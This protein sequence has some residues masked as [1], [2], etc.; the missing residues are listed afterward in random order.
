MRLL[1]VSP[2]HSDSQ[3][4]KVLSTALLALLAAVALAV[5][6]RT[7]DDVVYQPVRELPGNW[8]DGH[9]RSEPFRIAWRSSGYVVD[10]ELP[11]T[12]VP[13]EEHPVDSSTRHFTQRCGQPAT[14]GVT[15]S[16]LRFKRVVAQYTSHTVRWCED[17]SLGHALR[18]EIGSFRAR[19]GTGY[20]IQIDAPRWATADSSSRVPLRL[21]MGSQSGAGSRVGLPAVV[22]LY[23]LVYLGII[24]LAL[25]TLL[26]FMERL[27]ILERLEAHLQRRRDN[28]PAA[29][30]LKPLTDRCR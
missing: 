11:D 20:S 4:I 22:C 7:M 3:G 10:L 26:V 9:F 15:W 28:D 27:Q 24:C 6:G 25:G 17:P 19:P 1:K 29:P 5:C 16:V 2:W 18:A 14:D 30:T 21:S 12:I 13:T 8:V 23:F